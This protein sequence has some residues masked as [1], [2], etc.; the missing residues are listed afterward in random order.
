MAG[1]SDH[2]E[3]N[4]DIKYLR[5][6]LS[7]LDGSIRLPGSLEASALLCKLD[8]LEQEVPTEQKVKELVLP[9]RPGLRSWITY[10]A[11]FALIVGLSYGMG[12]YQQ[13]NHLALD[14]RSFEQ[15]AE[16]SPLGEGGRAF[17]RASEEDTTGAAAA[18]VQAEGTLPATEQP[19]PGMS[20]RAEG[21]EAQTFAGIDG[22]YDAV[23]GAGM[24][25]I[26]GSFGAFTLSYRPTDAADPDHTGD[27]S[28]VLL[29]LDSE[30]Q[31]I[32]SQVDLPFM[33]E[34]EAFHAHGEIL[35]L[36]GVDGLRTYIYT[37]D[38][39]DPQ[40]PDT[41][42]LL[43]QPGTLADEIYFDGFLYVA[44]HTPGPWEAEQTILLEESLSEGTAILTLVNLSE[45]T[46]SQA[47]VGGAGELIT[48]Y[49]TEAR[50]PFTAP[51]AEGEE[52]A[53]EWMARIDII[54]G[55]MQMLF[56]G[57]EQV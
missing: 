31:T 41:L 9:R 45:N 12:Y 54:I 28:N 30:G 44:S 13:Q 47:A 6:A 57:T 56:A 7:G 52:G 36:V 14:A 21:G 18:P 11:A 40:S 4:L 1:Y 37:I 27:A 16:L 43:S 15:Q 38:Y 49:R 20:G 42:L 32:L 33:T 19:L 48:L 50:I 34:I 39:T 35:A 29:L 5:K 3:Q 26:L 55:A 8:G 51:A 10:A 17:D 24:G 46:S 53:V 22:M 25:R 2:R 23:G